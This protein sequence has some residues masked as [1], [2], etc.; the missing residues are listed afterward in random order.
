MNPYMTL[1]LATSMCVGA[2]SFGVSG[3]AAY[4]SEQS[5]RT[6]GQ[7]QNSNAF[8]SASLFED[9]DALAEECGHPGWDGYGAPA[10]SHE[11]IRQARWVLQSLPLGTPR[12]TLGIE[13]DGQVTLEWYR[14]PR[15]TLSVSIAPDGLLHYAALIGFARQYGTEAFTGQFPR[16]LLGLL[17]RVQPA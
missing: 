3:E 7:L 9:L 17:R 14:S 8:G 12:P 11:S 2:P 4:I 1:T 13:S 16:N 6:W 15:R 5:A 10:V